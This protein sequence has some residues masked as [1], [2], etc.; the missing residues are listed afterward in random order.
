M[1]ESAPNS[2]RL[3]DW[4]ASWQEYS[5]VLSSPPIFRKWAGIG[6]LSAVLER[7]IW[8]KTKGSNLFP[9]L[10]IILVGPPGVG[11][12]AILS[13]AERILRAVPEI[14]VAPSSLTTAS[15][16]DTLDLAKRKI[17]RP[18]QVPAFAQF[19]SLQ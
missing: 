5:N 2:R 19:N 6:I 18:T 13:H 9:N 17:I 10:Y 8:T 7:K 3:P 16:I 1:T 15:L 4:L 12:S 14:F 11:K